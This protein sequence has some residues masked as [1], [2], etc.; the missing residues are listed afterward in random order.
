MFLGCCCGWRGGGVGVLSSVGDEEEGEAV[1]EDGGW[2][3]VDVGRG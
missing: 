3:G 2:V 1:L